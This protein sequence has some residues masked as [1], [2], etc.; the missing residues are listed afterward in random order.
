MR[1]I[2][3]GIRDEFITLLQTVKADC[4]IV[5]PVISPILTE[6]LVAHLQPAIAVKILTQFTAEEINTG[7]LN[8]DFGSKL[9]PCFQ[10]LWIGVLE[11][12]EA[13]LFVFD[14]RIALLTTADLTNNGL[15][16]ST[17]YGTMYTDPVELENIGSAVNELLSSATGFSSS[18]PMI[19]QAP[20]PPGTMDNI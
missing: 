10:D 16:A 13:H 4:V 1:I 7:V 18:N 20:V 15:L 8:Y 14:Q 6:L 3:E 5:T 9:E 19:D 17:D 12:L 11:I 2:K